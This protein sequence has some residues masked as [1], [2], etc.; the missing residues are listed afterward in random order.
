MY[1]SYLNH[2]N[3]LYIYIIYLYVCTY[4]CNKHSI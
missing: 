4:T 2:D 1:M 3:I